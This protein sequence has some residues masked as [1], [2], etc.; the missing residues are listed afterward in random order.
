MDTKITLSFNEDIIKKAHQQAADLLEKTTT[1]SNQVINQVKDTH[2]QMTQ[3]LD[4]VLDHLFVSFC[5]SFWTES[6]PAIR[7]F[8]NTAGMFPL[9]SPPIDHEFPIQTCVWPLARR[10][11]NPGA[12]PSSD[13]EA[14][15]VA[16]S[17]LPAVFFGN[18]FDHLCHESVHGLG[19]P[20]VVLGKIFR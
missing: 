8:V 17:T 11:A 20:L 3:N 10:G 4:K 7:L 9:T 12:K 14:G 1:A 5:H 15:D 18:L 16:I 13:H 6:V 19:A 2:E